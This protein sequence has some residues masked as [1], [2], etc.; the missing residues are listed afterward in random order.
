VV[1]AP[2]GNPTAFVTLMPEYQKN[3]ITFDLMRRYPE[4]QAGTMD[5]LFVSILKWAKEQGFESVSL[6]T[7]TFVGL[8]E[9]QD[10][11]RL[12]RIMHTISDHLGRFYSFKSLHFFKNK[13]GP[14]WEPRYLACPGKTSLPFVF[15]HSI[16][17]PY[18]G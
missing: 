5:F 3:E 2:D 12:E 1:Y 13:F 8:G 10:A 4:A 18:Q 9:R 7:S 17:H 11:L 14:C 15:F 6:G 16:V